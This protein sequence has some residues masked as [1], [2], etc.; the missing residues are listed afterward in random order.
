MGRAS[1]LASTPASLQLLLWLGFG[2]L[3]VWYRH[4]YLLTHPPTYIY[5]AS[6]PMKTAFALGLLCA[7]ASAFQVRK[8]RRGLPTLHQGQEGVGGWVDAYQTWVKE[9]E[10]DHWCIIMHACVCISLLSALGGA[11]SRQIIY[12]PTHP[13]TQTLPNPNRPPSCPVRP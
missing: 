13:P 2:T 12:P 6:G 10:K 3:P 4:I 8:E 9:G 7:G 11:S 1:C 5:T